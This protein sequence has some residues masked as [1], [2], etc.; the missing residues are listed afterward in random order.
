MNELRVTYTKYEEDIDISALESEVLDCEPHFHELVLLYSG[1]E[2]YKPK[3]KL[4][5]LLHGIQFLTRE[6]AAHSK[7]ASRVLNL[8]KYLEDFY[9]LESV[10]K[11][12][13]L[14]HENYK[15]AYVYLKR[16]YWWQKS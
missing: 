13:I 4:T 11:K 2:L 8:E 12:Y 16:V 7:T 15:D 9:S 14:E 5:E 1:F 3:I 10:L 6:L